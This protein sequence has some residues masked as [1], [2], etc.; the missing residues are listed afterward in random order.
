[1]MTHTRV[2]GAPADRVGVSAGDAPHH[3]CSRTHRGDQPP[4]AGGS[5]AVLI[6]DY[7]I[8]T[9]QNH[10]QDLGRVAVPEA[11]GSRG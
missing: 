5:R 11:G 2:V 1:M 8:R 4:G 7:L 6:T 10:E 3:D 9:E